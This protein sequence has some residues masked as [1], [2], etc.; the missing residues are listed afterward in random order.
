MAFSNNDESVKLAKEK[1]RSL[2]NIYTLSQRPNIT[3]I[4]IGI[5]LYILL[6]FPYIIQ[7][8]NTKST[9]RSFGSEKEVYTSSKVRKAHK[10]TNERREEDITIN[11]DN[12]QS[13]SGDYDSFT[14]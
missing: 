4:L 10:K 11:N 2:R 9:Y 1:L 6:L 5:V 7:S 13:N 3:S 14:M 8:R 12:N